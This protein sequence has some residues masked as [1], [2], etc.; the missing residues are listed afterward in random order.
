MVATFKQ[1]LPEIQDAWHTFTRDLKNAW[2]EWGPI[3][4]Q[5]WQGV[6]KPAF[7]AIA[8]GAAMLIIGFLQLSSAAASMAN[9]LAQAF[10]FMWSVASSSLSTI[11]NAAAI[12]FSWVPGIGG[13]L[14]AASNE[15][16]A[17]RDRVNNALAGIHDKDVN[18]RLTY[19]EDHVV[20]G[21]AGGMGM[22]ASG[23]IYGGA[24]RA[25]AGGPRNN[26]TLV[27]EH[28]PE[29]VNLKPGTMVTPA[30]KTRSMMSGSGS[31]NGQNEPTVIVVSGGTQLDD[32]LCEIL[33]KAIGRR[34]GD[35]QSVLGSA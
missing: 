35:V 15:F 28:G 1:Y 29:L 8:Y 17:F 12:A 7:V 25:A 19:Y 33:R 16:N 5:W 31:S 20:V 22:K 26:M 23:G 24:S 32:M 9:A 30:G 13:K 18:V 2:D 27:G 4:L 11:L 6:G 21:A 3:V 34:G 14:I 10:R